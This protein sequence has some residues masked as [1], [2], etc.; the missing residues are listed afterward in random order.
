MAKEKADEEAIKVFAANL[1]GLLMASPLGQIKTL[2]IDPGFR[3]GCKVVCLNEQGNLKEHTTIYP[4]P[5]Q[6]RIDESRKTLKHL[7]N[8][9]AIKAI[10]VGNGT[11][12]RETMAFLRENGFEELC[13]TY[14]VNE[15]GASI[16]S[17]SAIARDEFPNHDVTVRGAISIARR[18]MDPMAE[19]VKIDAKSIGIGQY[20]HDV[21]QVRLRNALNDTVTYCVNAVGIELNTASE[22][23]LAHVSG[24]GSITAKNVVAF[25]KKNGP[26]KSK[27]ELLNVKRLGEKVFV[28]CAG[29]LRI[30]N[31][32]NPLDNTA[33][34][35]ERYAL[36]QTMASDINCEVEDLITHPEF[37]DQIRLQKYVDQNT[38][39]ETL[40]DIL[41]EL[42]KPGLDPRGKAEN[43]RFADIHSFDD[44]KEKMTLPA[45]VTNVV[46]FGAFVDLGI[47]ESGFIHI[48]E[49]S[50]S[51]VKDPLQVVS[52]GE[53]LIVKVIGIDRERRRISCS[54]K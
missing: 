34:H 54:L 27:K 47:K 31:G 30:R 45:V 39:L 8:S 40:K 17:A 33:I 37:T 25:R 22:H 49:L 20:Q 11:A 53:K 6:N 38:G 35:P 44:V 24:L 52:S 50:N 14:M 5:P 48:S 26:F 19:L 43:I 36:V 28:Q 41:N 10:A 29:F 4:H 21:N 15:A 51:F 23:L 3:T 13:E 16:Y 12:G 9:H 32:N 1:K 46:A 2:G 7:I 18:L 42:R